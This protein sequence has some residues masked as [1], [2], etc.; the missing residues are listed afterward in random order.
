MFTWPR[1]RLPKSTVRVASIPESTTAMV[2][3]FGLCLSQST[4]A[5]VAQGQSC[6]FEYGS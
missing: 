5:P 6:A 2:P 4:G 1:T 3:A